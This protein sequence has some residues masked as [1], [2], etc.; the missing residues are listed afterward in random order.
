[1]RS[2]TAYGVPSPGAPIEK[3]TIDRR[4]LGDRDILVEIAFVGICHS[5]VHN[6]L[7]EWGHT[8]FPLVPGH[9]ITGVVR[10]TGSSVS[11]LGEGDRVGVGVIVDSCRR[12]GQCLAGNEQYCEDGPVETYNS[13]DRT[14]NST[15][16]GYSTH[17][18]VDEHFVYRIPDALTME[19]AGPL[20]CAGI[21][22]YSPLRHWGAGPGTRVAVVGLGGLGHM[23]VKI[24]AALGAEVTVLSRTAGKGT[25]SL[26]LGAVRHVT[27]SEPG[28]L[29]GAEGSFDLVVSTV[30]A[31]LDLDRYV[32][33]LD[34]DGVFVNVGLP[35]GPL[36][37]G[38]GT[39]VGRR[40]SIAG[41]MIGGVAETQDMLD[42]CASHGLGADVEVVSA[43]Q[44][45]A[46]WQRVLTG[47]V[48]YRFVI[49][50][51]TF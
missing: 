5:D 23:A 18:V 31:A 27:T 47:D 40:R 42:F 29:N 48:R 19:E 41:S 43:P 32:P 9:E 24:A 12:C 22:V 17:I 34:V 33:L 49:D 14:G 45:D 10:A 7:D 37:L 51:A 38:A 39:L 16:G 2:V 35:P 11:G 25:D 8:T 28:A 3:M 4:D 1:M 6:A 30:S 36:A 26:R 46:A 50:A 44:I 21:T 15:Y 20:L 13:V